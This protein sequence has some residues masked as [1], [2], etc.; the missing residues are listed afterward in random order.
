MIRIIQIIHKMR[1]ALY[2]LRFAN[3]TLDEIR[4]APIR[5]SPP[6]ESRCQ[7]IEAWRTYTAPDPSDDLYKLLGATYMIGLCRSLSEGRSGVLMNLPG[8]R[9]WSR[10]AEFLMG[11]RSRIKDLV[12]TNKKKPLLCRVQAEL[13]AGVNAEADMLVGTT[14]WFFIGGDKPSE[15]HR[16]DRMVAVLLTTHALRNSGHQ[17]TKITLLQMI[18][19]LTLDLDVD[20]WISSPALSSP[21]LLTAFIQAR[22]Q[23]TL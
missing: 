13:V 7:L 1:T 12:L 9:E 14:A 15:L 10:C 19:G 20:T 17:I 21:A 18:T 2:N 4:F 3:I 6:Q 22:V 8:A 11:L 16:L 23:H 5:H